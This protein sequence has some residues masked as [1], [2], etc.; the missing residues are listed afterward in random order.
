MHVCALLPV[1]FC[2]KSVCRLQPAIG[3]P[4]EMHSADEVKIIYIIQ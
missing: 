4:G 3:I 2:G 1:F